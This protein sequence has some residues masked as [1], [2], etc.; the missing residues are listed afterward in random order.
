MEYKKLWETN[1]FS[2]LVSLDP[3]KGTDLSLFLKNATACKGRADAIMVC[4]SPDAIMRMSPIGACG[5][6]VQNGIRPLLCVNNRDRNR[7]AIQGDLLSAWNAGIRD[8][9]IEDG[10]DPSYGDHPL[11]RPVNDASFQEM[12]EIGATL[13]RG[14][15]VAGNELKGGTDFFL[16]ATVEWL[17]GED[18]IERE[19]LKMRQ[20]ANAGAEFFVTSPQFDIPRAKALVDAAKGIGKAVFVGIM[21]L[22]SVGMARY[23]NEV[24]GISKVPDDI[25]DKL[26]SAP[27]KA[28][29]G[30]EIAAEA[31]NELQAV[32][33][34]VVIWPIG[35]EHKVPALLDAIG[36]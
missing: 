24:P 26:S 20:A 18:S 1:E 8:V 4:D 36:R 19:F 9:V 25:I 11:A 21:I 2:V 32:A 31:I 7:L 28:K 30:I 17:D 34:G 5:T 27:V 16:G 6:L 15:D 35:W 23:L 13:N 12:V 3:P 22:K 14:K 33:D 29:A 10:K